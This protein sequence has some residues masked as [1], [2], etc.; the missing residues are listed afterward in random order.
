MAETPIPDPVTG[1]AG[2]VPGQREPAVMGV[3][4]AAVWAMASQY[5]SFAIQFVTSVL[6]S[7][8]FLAPDEVGLFS[9]ALAAAMLVAVLQDF[10]LSRYISGLPVLS[11]E[12]VNRCS[13]VAFIFS[14]LITAAIAALAWPL[15]EFYGLPGLAPLLVI[16]AGS[17]LFLPLSVVPLALM[18]RAMRFG[19]HF[20]VNVGGAMVHAV[21]ALSLAWLGY[22]SFALAWAV[23]ASGLAR[24]LIAQALQP[25]RTFPLRLD[26]LRP[27]LGFGG[28]AS[29]LYITG[30]LGSRSPDLIVGRLVDLFAVGLF[31]RASS[32]AEQFRSLIAG[33]IGGVFYPAFARIRDA[34]EPL[35]PAYLRV[36]A[37]YTAVVWPGM[38]GLALAAWPIV[39]ML[40]GDVWIDTAPLLTLI[41]LQAAIM[42]ALPLVSE[43]PILL[44]RMNRLLVLNMAETALSIAL[45][46]AGSLWAGAWGAAASRLVYAVA[47]MAIYLGFMRGLVG[48]AMRDWLAILGKS[49]LASLAALAPLALTY[50]LWLGP[51]EI[52]APVLLL[53][54]M[55]GGLGWAG[56]MFAVRHPALDDMRRMAAPLLRPV[57]PQAADWLAMER[58]R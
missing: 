36:V 18:A 54:V 55:L 46:V 16:I 3:K 29:T 48:F 5:G 44:G 43:L 1:P 30:A 32:L 6:I 25:A 58:A 35:A 26:G 13:S 56:A 31:S 34:G 33:A 22:S 42:M 27:V 45:L 7:R 23:L 57:L 47:F 41:A 50:A 17:Y 24:G 52:T 53:A 12:E 51:Q 15:A 14:L 20:A 8:F 28:K 49:L 9:I 37:G 19:G 10:G 40:Y 11:A 38:A 2:G 4:A 21:I 39:M